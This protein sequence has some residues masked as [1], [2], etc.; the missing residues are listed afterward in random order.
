M[1]TTLFRGISIIFLS[2]F[3]LFAQIPSPVSFYVVDLPKEVRQNEVV[4]ITI[5]AIIDGE[6]HLYGVDLPKGGPVA[7]KFSI[8][9]GNAQ[10]NGKV[11]ESEAEIVFDPNFK[12]KVS[13]HKSG[14]RFTIPIKYTDALIGA[15]LVEVQVLFMVCNDEVCLPP[16]RKTINVP[17]T[18]VTSDELNSSK[19]EFFSNDKD[20]K[21][22]VLN[23]DNRDLL[24]QE[25]DY[26]SLLSGGLASFIWIALTA[27]FAALLT[28]CVFP[29]IPLTVSFFSKQSKGKNA[30]AVVNALLFGIAI[31]GMFTIL[32]ALLSL[33]LGAT[34]A[35]QFASNPWVNLTIGLI[36]IV[37]AI[38]L[39]GLFE[40][41]LPYQITN[42]LN[43]KSNEK[44]GLVGILFMGLTISA[45]SFSCTAPFV[46]GVLAATTKGEWFYPI[47]GML[48]F[49][50]AFSTPFVL[51][52]MFPNWLMSLP[53]SGSWMNQVKVILG[54]LELGAAIKFL[55]NADLVWSWGI[56]SRPFAIASWI[57]ICILATLYI[58]GKI[59]FE[60]E[61]VSENV[62][63]VKLLIAIPI[64]TFAFY[65]IPGL[66]GS[67][68]GVW[69]AWLPPKQA[70]DV[71]L[72]SGFSSSTSNNDFEEGWN[73]TIDEASQAAVQSGKYIFIDFT[74]FTCTNCRA[75]E[76][77]VFPNAEVKKRFDQFELVKLY[78]DGGATGP[79]NQLYQFELTGSVA[80]PTY[81]FIDA[82]TGKLIA[83]K[84][85]FI[86]KD[87]FVNFLDAV[88]AR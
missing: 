68:L 67:S 66:L 50:T 3:F 85:G 52:A 42:F 80:L 81:A 33:I 48:I 29:M 65:L 38:S 8:K 19:S 32:G 20:G 72:V 11:M 5:E 86:D 62:T 56:I 14:A 26:S 10:I 46:G 79:E 54:F 71:S 55:S 40:L 87:D 2:P 16:T 57:A 77:N 74:G 69:D 64:L 27:G 75:M 30:K 83:K 37:F 34:G 47:L 43:Q 39:L 35:N 15:G 59:K 28:P 61:R 24:E 18:I 49:S 7:T 73:S 17:L 82:N 22:D 88:L 51:F 21:S 41:Q 36:F 70:T 84:S 58:L 1:L 23:S 53:K 78:T 44:S 4:T 9:S 63:A 76:A 6:W 60:Y 31:I 45:V 13:W 25:N 12:M